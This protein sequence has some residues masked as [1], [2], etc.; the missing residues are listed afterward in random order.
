[1]PRCISCAERRAAIGHG[2]AALKAGRYSAAAHE[3]KTVRKSLTDDA[4]AFAQALK[5]RLGRR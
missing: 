1:M 4:K 2:A 5:A 3:I